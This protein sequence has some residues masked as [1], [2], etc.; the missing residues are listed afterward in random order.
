MQQR[1]HSERSNQEETPLHLN[2]DSTL[3]NSSEAEKDKSSSP[4]QPDQIDVPGTDLGEGDADKYA[5]SDRAGTAERKDN[6]V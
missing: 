2:T 3:Q 1:K 5:G 4:Q 6:R